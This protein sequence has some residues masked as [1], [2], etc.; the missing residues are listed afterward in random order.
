MRGHGDGDDDDGNSG[1]AGVGC[2]GRARMR[3]GARV[4]EICSGDPRMFRKIGRLSHQNTTLANEHLNELTSPEIDIRSYQRAIG[5][6]MYPM[7]G[8]RPD[9]AYTV[10]GL[11]WHAACPGNEHRCALDRAFHYLRAMSD[12]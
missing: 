5:M 10:A 4:R 12:D 6:L 3:V 1:E 7:L 2:E 9:P 11:S 8:T